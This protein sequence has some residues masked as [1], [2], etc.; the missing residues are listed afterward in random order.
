[1]TSFDLAVVG[2]GAV[3]SAA[4]V[5]AARAGARVVGIDS[6]SPPHALGS[7]HGE[8]RIVREAIGEGVEYTPFA[9]RSFALWDQL[10]AECGETLVVRCGLLV[11]GETIPHATHLPDGFLQSTISTARASQIAHEVLSAAQVRARF[12]AYATFDG[13]RAYFE[14][15]AGMANPERIVAVQLAR[16]IE[17]G[18]EVRV[19]CP[20][21]SLAQDGSGV[22]IR[23]Q[24]DTIRAGR[25]ILAAGAWT[26]GFLP[27]EH[28]SRLTVTRQ[29]VHWF[30]PP[31]EPA[32]FAP[33]RMPVFIWDDLYG[34]PIASPGGGIKVATEALNSETAPDEVRA[35][36]AEDLALVLPRVRAAFPQLGAHLRS[37]TCL[38]TSLRDSRFWLGPHPEMEKVTVVSACSGH[39]FKHAAAVGEAAVGGP[40]ALPIPTAWTVSGT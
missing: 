17:L 7:T 18:A 5:A 27:P 16:A 23:T 39:G 4:L 36:D 35:V 32:D 30:A 11:L 12:P 15:G 34:F 13:A 21:L 3:G 8:T 22:L 26:G 14:P 1:M 6:F 10:S 31:P 38:Y 9:Q 28:V 40:L 24:S 2:L 20:A 19:N 25:V 37:A 29:T 33:E